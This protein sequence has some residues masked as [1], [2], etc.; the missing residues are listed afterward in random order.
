MDNG[1]AIMRHEKSAASLGDFYFTLREG[2][3][4]RERE[5][6]RQTKQRDLEP[7]IRP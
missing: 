4:E 7:V 6:D 2:E 1:E 5:R 3:R